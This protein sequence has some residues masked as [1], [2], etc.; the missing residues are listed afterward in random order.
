MAIEVR[1]AAAT[2]VSRSIHAMQNKL[3]P[4]NFHPRMHKKAKIT[5]AQT[6]IGVGKGGAAGCEKKG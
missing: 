2:S 5:R 3:Q 6:I 1:A 4:L